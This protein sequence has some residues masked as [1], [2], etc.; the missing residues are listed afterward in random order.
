MLS[1]HIYR[2]K[3]LKFVVC[4]QKVTA[5][6]QYRGSLIDLAGGSFIQG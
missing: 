2:Y 1:T 6:R 5:V 4:C 3:W